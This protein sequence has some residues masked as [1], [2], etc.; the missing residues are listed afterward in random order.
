MTSFFDLV[1]L[2]KASATE[3]PL[4]AL[5]AILLS[6]AFLLPPL[7]FAAFLGSPVLVPVALLLLVRSPCCSTFLSDGRALAWHQTLSGVLQFRKLYITPAKKE[8]IQETGSESEATI[9]GLLCMHID[10]MCHE[11]QHE[12]NHSSWQILTVLHLLLS[13]M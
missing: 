5:L 6:T 8:I 10:C 4:M 3:H 7:V 11:C 9:A 13:P 12:C 1:M 2:A